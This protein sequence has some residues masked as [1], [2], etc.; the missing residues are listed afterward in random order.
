[1]IITNYYYWQQCTFIRI[2]LKANFDCCVVY[3]FSSHDVP[4]MQ[5]HTQ[6]KPNRKNAIINRG[7]F[8]DNMKRKKNILD[9]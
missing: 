2:K 9:D 3:F 7:R 6:V 1:M 5:A 4:V 8:A